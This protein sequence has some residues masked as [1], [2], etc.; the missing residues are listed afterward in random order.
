[1]STLRGIVLCTGV[2]IAVTWMAI[3]S[4]ILADAHS[5][6]LGGRPSHEVQGW[7]L[8]RFS[9]MSGAINLWQNHML[10]HTCGAPGRDTRGFHFHIRMDLPKN[11]ELPFLDMLLAL[12]MVPQQS[13]IWAGDRIGVWI[14]SRGL[15][16]LTRT[17]GAFR[18]RHLRPRLR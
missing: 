1:M 9:L 6:L 4:A 3:G 12:H 5:A 2:V 10:S 11:L 17:A 15:A 18:Q 14:A 13:D 7:V 16:L 8:S